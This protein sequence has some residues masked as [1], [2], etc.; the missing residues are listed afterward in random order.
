[1]FYIPLVAVSELCITGFYGI[2]SPAKVPMDDIYCIAV[3]GA[4][5]HSHALSSKTNLHCTL[6]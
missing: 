2:W 4:P 6:P 1:M 5:Q 3:S